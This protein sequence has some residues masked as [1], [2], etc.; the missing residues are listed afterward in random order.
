MASWHSCE[1]DAP[2]YINHGC[3]LGNI[4]LNL[5]GILYPIGVPAGIF[6]HSNVASMKTSTLFSPASRCGQCQGGVNSWTKYY[7]ATCTM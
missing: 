6:R 2:I 3:F 4:K 7:T 5:A 1:N